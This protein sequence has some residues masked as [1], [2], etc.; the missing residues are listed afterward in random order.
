MDSIVP[1]DIKKTGGM[2]KQLEIFVCAKVIFCSIIDLQKV[3]VNGSL[4]NIVEVVW[5]HF[6]RDQM[7]LMEFVLL[8]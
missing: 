2:P 6:R 7:E 1:V 4:G 5:P 3:L 8:K